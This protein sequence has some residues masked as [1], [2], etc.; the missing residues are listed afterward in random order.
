M[1]D[2][3]LRITTVSFRVKRLHQ[4]LKLPAYAHADD[5]GMDLFCP[6]TVS[7]GARMRC[8][9]DLGFATEFPAGYVAEIR[10]KSGLAA[11]HGI[12]TLAGIIDAG[13]RGEWKVTMLN[14]GD[15]EYTFE[16]G[17]K[18]AQALLR[19]VEHAAIKD[20]E[21]LSEHLRGHGGHGSTGRF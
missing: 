10:D 4:D 13:Y 7:V 1:P 12:H 2:D 6:N 17:Q 5:A 11:N 15:A 14:T 3:R 8:T 21:N 20:V 18:I 9:I 19:K 16:A